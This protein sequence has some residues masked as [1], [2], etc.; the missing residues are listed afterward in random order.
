MSYCNFS[1]LILSSVVIISFYVVSTRLFL[2]RKGLSDAKVASITKE[3][4]FCSTFFVKI[5]KVFKAN[6]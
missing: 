1:S 5:H 6:I 2:K 3:I 4:W